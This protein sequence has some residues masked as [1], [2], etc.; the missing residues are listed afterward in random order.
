MTLFLGIAALSIVLFAAWTF[1]RADPQVLAQRLQTGV[2]VV[3]MLV[4]GY[5]GVTG[6][7]FA[8]IPLAMFAAGLLGW[9]LRPASIGARMRKTPGQVSRVRASAVEME[10]DHDSG[11]MRGK[12]LIGKY[13]DVPLDALDRATLIGVLGEVDAESRALIEAYL[14]R[15]DAGWRE[16]VEKDP[17]ARSAGQPGHGP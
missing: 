8:A 12:M 16:D 11:A 6:R 7:L 3:L 13:Q 1:L 4:A 5:L 17:G 9:L 14:D 10:L 2:G 15:R